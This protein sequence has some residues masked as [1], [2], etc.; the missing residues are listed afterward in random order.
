MLL[1]CLA[2]SVLSALACG[3]APALQST[4]ADL[5]NG[6]KSAE[7]DVTRTQTP[8]GPERAGRRAGGDVADAA[9]RH[10][11]DDPWLPAQLRRGHRIREG[12]SADGGVRSAPGAVQR[13]TDATVLHRLLERVRETP[14]VESAALTQNPPLGLEGFDDIAFV[15]DGF[16]MPRDRA[17]FTSTMDTIDE[18][19]FSTMGI[20][21]VRGRGFRASDTA[22]APRVAVVNEQFAKHYWPGAR[23]GGQAH[24]TRWRDRHAGRNRRRRRDGQVSGHRREAEPISCT[25]RF[26]SIRSR[27]WF[28]WCARAAIR[29][30]WSVP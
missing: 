28:C 19:Y 27:E 11:P 26:V 2:L 8:V 16:Q 15:P 9:H 7:V 18:G 21:I 20:P 6:L 3:L 12:S 25:C 23:S 4:R 29:C 30:S 22:D 14:G 10:L 1:A 24:P 13:R 5:V 17:T